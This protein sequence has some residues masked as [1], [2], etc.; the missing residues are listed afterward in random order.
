MEVTNSYVRDLEAQQMVQRLALHIPD[1][2]VFYLHQGIIRRHQQ[3]WVGNNSTLRTKIV[4]LFM[5]RLT[6]DI[7]ASMQL[8]KG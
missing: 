5:S 8:I 7:Q 6:G 1:E 2:V 4:Q 3:I